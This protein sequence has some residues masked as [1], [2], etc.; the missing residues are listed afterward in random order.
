MADLVRQ[1]RRLMGSVLDERRMR[2][3]VD[4]S[5]LRRESVGTDTRYSVAL[6]GLVEPVWAEAYR[7]LQGDSTSF[8]RLRLDATT[9]TVS[10]TCRGIDGPAQVFE[11][12]ERLDALVKNVNQQVTGRKY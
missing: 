5:T 4:H 9:G 12:L 2:V 6:T 1:G 11:I 10:F 8:R 3:G 7:I